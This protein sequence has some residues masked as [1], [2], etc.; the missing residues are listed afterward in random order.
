MIKKRISVT[1]TGPYLE[2]LGRLVDAGVYAD[3]GEGSRTVCGAS[4]E[5]MG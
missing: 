3:R 5:A 4:S 2:A 1:L